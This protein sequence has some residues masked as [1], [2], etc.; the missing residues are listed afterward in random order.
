[1]MR[2]TLVENSAS[3]GHLLVDG[4]ESGGDKAREHDEKTG[5]SIPGHDGT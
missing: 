5:W 2:L 4:V 1:M 3:S